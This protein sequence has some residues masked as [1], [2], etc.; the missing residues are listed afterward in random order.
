ML[1]YNLEYLLEVFEVESSLPPQSQP[2]DGKEHGKPIGGY[3]RIGGSA[4]IDQTL[5][6]SPMWSLGVIHPAQNWITKA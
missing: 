6:G 4:S 1:Y 2:A 5:E 3:P